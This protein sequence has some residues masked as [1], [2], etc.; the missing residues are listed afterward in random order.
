MKTNVMCKLC[1]KYCNRNQKLIQC[2][3]CKAWIHQKCANLNLTNEQCSKLENFNMTYFCKICLCVTLPFQN[4][5]NQEFLKKIRNVATVLM[6]QFNNL[7]PD[8]DIEENVGIS[9][10]YNEFNYRNLEWFDSIQMN[11]RSLP[12]N[13]NLIQIY[14]SYI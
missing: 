7:I 5:S 6:K 11:T 14:L 10:I 1:S 4:L 13:I 9:D 2:E 12:K 3:V 8:K